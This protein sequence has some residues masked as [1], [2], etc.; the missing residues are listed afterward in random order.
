MFVAPTLVAFGQKEEV[1]VDLCGLGSQ[2]GTVPRKTASGANSLTTP[3]TSAE[4]NAI[5][6]CSITLNASSF[7][8]A[9]ADTGRIVNGTSANSSLMIVRLPLG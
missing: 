9:I 6:N 4:S 8:P 5:L 3:G 2:L 7:G 1:R